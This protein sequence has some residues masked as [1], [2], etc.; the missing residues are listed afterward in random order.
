MYKFTVVVAFLALGLPSLCGQTSKTLQAT[1]LS[2]EAKIDGDLSDACWQQAPLLA[3]FM[4]STPVFGTAPHCATEVRLFYTDIALY[5]SARCFDPDARGVREDFSYRDG[6]M[7][8]DWFRVSLDTWN[9]NQLSF[10]FT[11]SAAGIQSDNRESR[12]N[13]NSRWQSAVQRSAD[14]WVLEIRIPFSALRYPAK[15]SSHTWGMQLSRFDRSTGE[16][17]TWSP[18]DP[19]IGDQVLQFGTLAGLTDIH[20]TSRHLLALHSEISYLNADF[21]GSNNFLTPTMGLDARLG[22]NESTSLDFTLLPPLS[23]AFDLNSVQYTSSGDNLQANAIL[24]PPRQLLAEEQTLFERGT[25][26]RENPILSNTDL[27]WRLGPLP[28]STFLISPDVTDQ[29]NALKLSTRGKGNWRFGLYN[30]ITG[31][32]KAELFSTVTN[33][34]R[35]ETLQSLTDYN[36][37]AAE[38]LLPNNGY[39]H[40]AN[41]SHLAGSQ[42]NTF[43]PSL[44]FRLRDR[45]NGYECAGTLYLSRQQVDT[46]TFRGNNLNLSLARIN[47]HWGWRLSHFTNDYPLVSA[48]RLPHVR[49]AGS[50]AEVQYRSFTPNR[51]FLNRKAAAGLRTSWSMSEEEATQLTLFANANVL[52]HS[53]R[54]LGL[55]LSVIPHEQTL[56]YQNGGTYLNRKLAPRISGSL[57]V[58]SDRRK[59]LFGSI[60]IDGGMSVRRELPELNTGLTGTWVIH[61]KLALQSSLALQNAFEYVTLLPVPGRW[62]FERRDD[63]KAQLVLDLNWYASRRLSFSAG[64][65]WYRYTYLNREALEI[66]P[67]GQLAPV[68]YELPLLDEITEATLR[69]GFQY[70]FRDISQIRFS[71]NLNPDADFFAIN[72]GFF[73]F[74]VQHQANLSAIL[75]FGGSGKP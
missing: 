43:E 16:L 34:T 4:T 33:E 5:V 30:T 7:T 26:L 75:M 1:R 55:G 8:G 11:V 6:Q 72:R 22:L 20:Q 69:F 61:P 2:A 25:S 47:R 60:H 46:N 64:F 42:M 38:Y 18:Q 32:V 71:Y 35:T 41:A 31:P 36:Y 39:I 17:S 23:Y 37:L 70:F 19:L 44:D 29:L 28:P 62:L 48:V 74:D 59:R 68:D 15:Q 14:G 9:D 27:L 21:F 63:W 51:Y 73:F 57:S 52:D 53:F 10:D 3:G 45:S 66:Q 50:S 12:S 56:R 40:L 65:G 67:D 54:N 24:P 58:E 49:T 13:L